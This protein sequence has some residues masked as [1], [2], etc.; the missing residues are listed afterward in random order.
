MSQLSFYSLQ[1]LQLIVLSLCWVFSGDGSQPL[2]DGCDVQ[3]KEAKIDKA[4]GALRR[5]VEDATDRNTSH[6][7]VLYLPLLP[8]VVM[9]EVV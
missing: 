8:R 6:N 3:E 1:C 4:L 9:P 7:K 5:S 2:I